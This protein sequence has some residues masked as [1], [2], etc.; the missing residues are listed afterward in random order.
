[1]P[2]Y[3]PDLKSVK[4]C[5]KAMTKNTGDKKY[6]GI[7]PKKENELLKARKQLSEYFRVIW[8]DEIQ[9]LEIE[10]A[11]TKENYDDKMSEAIKTKFSLI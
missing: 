4:N 9:A 6:N 7:I 1:M 5:A 8:K 11:V 10:L 3:F 2:M